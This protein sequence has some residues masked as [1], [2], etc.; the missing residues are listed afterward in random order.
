MLC[1]FQLSKPLGCFSIYAVPIISDCLLLIRNILTVD[2][3]QC[4][5]RMLLILFCEQ[6]GEVIV[7]VEV[8]KNYENR[9]LG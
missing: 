9:V 3:D 5:R 2:D 4:Q 8:F 1:F 6:F 7:Y